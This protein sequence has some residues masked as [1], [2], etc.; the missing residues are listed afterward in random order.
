MI[1]S[2]VYLL[3]TLLLMSHAVAHS[4]V[5]KRTF[6]APEFTG[7]VSIEAASYGEA[8]LDYDLDASNGGV[9]HFTGCVQV[10]ATKEGD[11]VASQYALL[12]LL[13]VNCQALKRYFSSAAAQR[14]Y[15]PARLSK[16]L[17]MAFPATALPNNISPEAMSRR[18]GKLL[19][20][21]EPSVKTSIIEGGSAEVVTTTEKIT[22]HVMA[23]A[24][25]DHDGAEDL[26][27][28]VDWSVR[29]A[30]GKGADLLL[31]SKKSSSSAIF[32]AWRF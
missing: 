4:A 14:S 17:V 20:T 5:L 2:V 6:N 22:Y 24:D 8:I 16:R 7:L 31:L 28:R 11:V 32:V 12:K 19:R 27:M 13:S 1:K 15:F 18:Q 29:K 23:R 21:Y 30:F 10:E 9:I 26:L 25:F 3:A